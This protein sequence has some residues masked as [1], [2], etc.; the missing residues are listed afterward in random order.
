MKINVNLHGHLLAGFNPWWK[1]QFGIEG[2]N[3]AQVVTD[4]CIEKDLGIYAITNDFPQ[5]F[6]IKSRFSYM[7]DYAQRLPLDYKLGK[8]G[9]NAFVIEKDDKKII[10]LNGQS[11]NVIDSRRKYELLTYGTSKVPDGM[12]FSDT[13]SYLKD[14]GLLGIA[15][16]P[17]A[18][19]HHGSMPEERLIELW[20]K[21]YID[22]VEFNGKIA[23]PKWFS[24]GKF[25]EYSRKHNENLI[26]IAESNDI[27]IIANDD[28]DAVSHI[29]TA[30]TIFP[31]DK[32]RKYN[33]EV[34]IQDLNSLIKSKDFEIKKDYLNFSEWLRY[35][36]WILTIKDNL[37]G[38]REKY[39]SG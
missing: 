23:V 20:N 33:N 34:I 2:K 9:E 3:L 10:Y 31:N 39:N 16:H 18:E 22:A 21:E 25:G 1:K 13:S 5:E 24:F 6:Q 19:G 12:N 26:E 17:F 37:L 15:E 30:Y 36:V 14:N 32:I 29:G 4:K 8:L 7:F 35:A 11:I 28:S 38:L 27:P